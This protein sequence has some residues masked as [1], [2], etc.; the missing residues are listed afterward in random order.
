MK[1]GGTV[2]PLPR[3]AVASLLLLAWSCSRAE[4]AAGEAP[5]ATDLFVDVAGD[6][7]LAAYEHYRGFTPYRY[8]V[9]TM[10]GGVGWIDYDLDGW[11]DAYLV[12]SAALPESEPRRE[13]GNHLLRNLEG[14]EFRDR[15]EA[16]GVGDTGFGM[17]CAVGDA[18]GDGDPDLLVANYGPNVFYRNA[19]DGTFADATAA[20]GLG[21]DG[22][23][24]SAGFFDAD[25]DGDLD[26][27]LVN[28]VVFSRERQR[29][30]A[31]SEG[32]RFTAYPH[33]D[34]F[35]AQPDRFYL[36]DGTGSFRDAAEEAG[37]SAVLPG[38]GLGVAFADVE[39]DG[40][41]DVYVA[42]D[43][44]PNFLFVNDGAGRFEE[45]GALT[46][47]AYNADGQTEASM[48]VGFGHV[49]D[50]GYADLFMTHL[51]LETNTLYRSRMRGGSFEF[52]DRTRSAGLAVPSIRQTGFGEIGRAHV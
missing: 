40:D 1:V 12:Q 13:V 30:L 22:W 8:L 5:P 52:V 41:V 34:L 39:N 38:K 28:Y 47:C 44:T 29:E 7:G 10:G 27:Y 11:P 4:P 25:R 2:N 49:D 35:D 31:A 32:G 36:N 26:L 14:R 37:L 23:G 45:R 9:E 6:V 48:G 50:D 46:G 17:G 19:A 3:V 15:T 33:P 51:D 43:S 21:D 16:A 18:D 24:V 42:N 20:S